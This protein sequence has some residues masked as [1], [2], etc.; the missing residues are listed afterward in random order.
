MRTEEPLMTVISKPEAPRVEPIAAH[1]YSAPVV[2][3][4]PATPSAGCWDKTW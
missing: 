4:I 2:H 3:E 1:V